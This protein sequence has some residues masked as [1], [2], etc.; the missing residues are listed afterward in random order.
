ML[1]RLLQ[2][3]MITFLLGLIAALNSSPQQQR[4]SIY[5]QPSIPKIGFLP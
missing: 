2:A 1:N 5:P 3:A 4:S